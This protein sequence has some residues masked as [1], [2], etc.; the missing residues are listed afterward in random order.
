MAKNIETSLTI[1]AVDKYSATLKKLSGVTGRFADKVRAD[2]KGLQNLRGPLKMIDDFRRQQQAVRESGTALAKA[3]EKVRQLGA[4]L[5]ATKNPT[6]QMRA[7]FDRARTA[8]ARL[9]AKHDSQRRKLAQLH[10]GLRQAGVNTANLA[11]EQRRL[12]GALKQ[13]NAGFDRQIAKMERLATMQKRI[14]DARG[15]FDRSMGVAT[16]MTASGYAM[17]HTGRRILRGM[18]API[19]AAIDFESA[20]ADVRKVVDFD[21]PEGFQN[22]SDGILDMSTRIPLTAE[23][24]ARITAAAGQIGL[25]NDDL[26]RFTEMAAKVGVAFD[27]SADQAGDA[28]ANIKTAMGLTLDETSA[29]FDAMNHLSNN[30]AATAAKTMEFMNRAGAVGSTFGFDDTET[31]AFGA[32][33]IAAG[34][35]ADTAATSFRA[36]GRALTRG[37]SATAR[38]LEAFEALGLSAETTAKAMQQDAVGTTMDVLRRM[39]ELPDHLQASTMSDLFGD[40]ARELTKLLANM[41]LLPE[42]LG[43]VA[44]E[45]SY[46]GSAEA[47]FAARAETTAN[48]IQLMRNQMT[49]LG[50]T[51][52]AVVLPHLN[53]LLGKLQ[54]LVERITQ[55][56]QEHPKLTQ[57]LVI[58]TAAIGALA[59]AAG[60][61]MIAAAGVVGALAMMRFG[62]AVLGA[63]GAY[64]ASSLAALGR[65]APALGAVAAGATGFAETVGTAMTSAEASVAAATASMNKN[66]RKLRFKSVVAALQMY[67]LLSKVPTDPEERKAWQEGNVRKMDE[68]LRS[69]PV[70]GGL[71][72]VYEKAYEAVRGE[73]PPSAVPAAPV[74]LPPDVAA[75]ETTVQAAAGQALPSAENIAALRDRIAEVRAEIQ[76]IQAFE[77]AGGMLTGAQQVSLSSKQSELADLQ[78]KLAAAETSAGELTAALQTLAGTDASPTINTA[79]IDAALARVRA[80]RAELAAINSASAGGGGGGGGGAKPK[81]GGSGRARGGPIRAGSPYLINERTKRSE[82]IVP[83][84]SGGVLNVGQ[85]QSAFARHLRTAG[86]AAA[87][88]LPS[89]AAAA[90]GAGGMGPV[91]V[92]IGSVSVTAPGGVSDPEG[93]VDEIEHRLGQRIADTMRASFTA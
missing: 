28:M 48:N 79:S 3:R 50:V 12:S 22:L 9:E 31:L 80:L 72:G 16:G 55:W 54:P 18:Q 68:T 1:R 47:E 61:L 65:S 26:L 6:A 92:Q 88:A 69:A 14:A 89:A 85:A 74:A 10:A 25:P 34:A 70:I 19:Q 27:I 11:G 20:M 21:T 86:M 64:A 8:A 49:R 23:E 93:L 33:M 90:P 58:G 56:A 39:A 15:R 17:M 40:E 7:E 53:N 24:L 35:G 87:V 84:R 62:L 83:S 51:I 46:L 60:G 91:S 81:G 63:R 38:Q 66:L 44:D 5:K 2:M 42:M 78:A 41:E 43:Q 13:A 52:G 30:S 32:A 36:M 45:T 82:W 37:D 29:L 4:A 71:M 73:P 59:A 67:N 77:S 75:A 57:A 76:A